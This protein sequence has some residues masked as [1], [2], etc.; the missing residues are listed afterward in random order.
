MTAG[1]ASPPLPVPDPGEV[2]RFPVVGTGEWWG[3]EHAR[4]YSIR[5]DAELVGVLGRTPAR[6]EARAEEF[7]ARA[8]T[9]L[10]RMV[11]TERPDLLSVCLPN[12]GHFD[13]TM[14]LIATGIP[15]LVE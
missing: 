11:E 1:P 10:Q 2:V 15:L 12:E 4:V 5:R 9:D 6:V 7:G 3:R 8:Y 13:A 14:E